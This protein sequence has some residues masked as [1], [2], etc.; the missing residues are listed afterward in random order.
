MSDTGP[1]ETVVRLV[2][3]FLDPVLRPAGVTPAQ[4]GSRPT[5]EAQVLYCAAR[6]ALHAR[7]PDFPGVGDD[8][9]G[10]VDLTVHIDRLGSFAGS[11]FDFDTVSETLVALGHPEEGPRLEGVAGAPLEVALPVLA[12]CLA[13]V[14]PASG[15]P[16]RD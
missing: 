5:G 11:S 14:F 4:G 15:H 8:P 7:F 10:C 6:D 16:A 13:L 3:R 9:G 12:E 1:V 2:A